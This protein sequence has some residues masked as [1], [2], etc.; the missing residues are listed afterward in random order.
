MRLVAWLCILG[1]IAGTAVADSEQ[2]SVCPCPDEA[3][4][5]WSGREILSLHEIAGLAAPTLWFS[6][7]EPLFRESQPIPRAHPCDAPSSKP[8][9][10]YQA[11]EIIHRG[12]EVALPPE[13]D[14]GFFEKV[15]RM[16]LKYFFYYPEDI[17]LGA[18]THDLEAVET[19]IRLSFANG[20]YR[21][22]V[23]NVTAL[24][25]GSRWYSNRLT[26]GEDTK[27]PMTIF[28]EEGKHGSCPD[29]NSDGIYTRG[30]D[31]NN[32][33]NDAWGVRD[34]MG[35]GLLLSS[36]YS[37]EMT[38]PRRDDHRLY[39]PETDLSCVNS[40]HSST[41]G[42][43]EGLGRYELRPGNQ[44]PRCESIPTAGEYLISLM[45]D[46]D[47]GQEKEPDQAS[48]DVSVALKSLK[49]PSSFMSVS[50]RTEGRLGA[51]LVFRGL[52]LSQGWIVP[53]VNVNSFSVSLG[54]MYTPSASRFFDW[55]L[56]A[57][58]RWRFDETEETRTIETEEGEKEVKFVVPPNWG[59]YWETGIK[60]RARVPGKI[61]PF[62]LG[63]N[64]AGVRVGLQA[65]GIGR[66][67]DLRIVFEIGAGAW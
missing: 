55:Y 51:A 12:R 1:W 13:K 2:G 3:G 23:E 66:L 38:K 34:I 9:V 53:K 14:P 56:V 54:A 58:P 8:V 46:H 42:R 15:D 17:G 24:A 47:F 18:H 5:I 67:D 27:F 7:D 61:R 32:T 16:I 22:Q 65:I 11:V 41:A 29:R 4:V 26:V 21:V 33:V 40:T 44:V 10:Y 25:H 59:F 43:S 49:S 45:D 64:F 30:Y 19:E 35:S 57:G 60:I 28:V 37:T 36:A 52:D 31:V 6:P 50:L 63:Y 39:P 62:V 48:S 20:C